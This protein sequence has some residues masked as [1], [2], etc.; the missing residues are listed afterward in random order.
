ML[1]VANNI[2]TKPSKRHVFENQITHPYR[3]YLDF[4]I[5][6]FDDYESALKALSHGTE[7]INIRKILA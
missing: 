7:I 4:D 1:V 3:F 2:F 5:S 6:D